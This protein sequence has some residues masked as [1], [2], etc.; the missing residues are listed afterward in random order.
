MENR[1]QFHSDRREPIQTGERQEQDFVALVPSRANGTRYSADSSLMHIHRQEL[2]IVA[3]NP[4][5]AAVAESRAVSRLVE[6]VLFFFGAAL[7]GLFLGI[8]L[9][10]GFV[11]VEPVPFF[12]FLIA[13]I[14]V[15]ALGVGLTLLVRSI[16]EDAQES[17]DQTP[18]QQIL[19][20][21]RELNSHAGR[22]IT[23]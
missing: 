21:V 11:P 7:A 23:D 12:L 17:L 15:F 9:G 18:V 8:L 20:P 6:I 16:R 1:M 14:S 4:G 19:I 2:R 10:K 3:G 13:G 22:R 5:A